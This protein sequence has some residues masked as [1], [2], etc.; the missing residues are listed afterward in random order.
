MLGQ[1]RQFVPRIVV[2][3]IATGCSAQTDGSGATCEPKSPSGHWSLSVGRPVPTPLSTTAEW[4]VGAVAHEEGN[5]EVS[6]TTDGGTKTASLYLPGDVD[7]PFAKGQSVRLDFHE[8][9]AFNSEFAGTVRDS[10][11]GP[12]RGRI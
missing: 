7:L 12:V 11:D 4:T 9:P 8:W 10:E 6:F 2:V 1:L 3:L 5:Q